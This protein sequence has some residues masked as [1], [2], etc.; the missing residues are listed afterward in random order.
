MINNIYRNNTLKNPKM[1]NIMFI[2]I[3]IKVQ[4]IIHNSK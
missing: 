1:M 3:R 4:M 2:K